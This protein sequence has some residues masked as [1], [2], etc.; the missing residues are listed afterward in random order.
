MY[1]IFILKISLP[2]I[3]AVLK[4]EGRLVLQTLPAALL[5]K[6]NETVS[7]DNPFSYH[8]YIETSGLNQCSCRLGRGDNQVSPGDAK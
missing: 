7:F 3:Q 1:G 6:R 8:L 2:K 5:C 4:V